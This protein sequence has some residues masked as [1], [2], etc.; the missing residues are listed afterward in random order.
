MFMRARAC[1][2][3]LYEVKMRFFMLDKITGWEVGVSAR[4]V[5]CVS[6]SED[7]FDDHFPGHPV[8]PGVLITEAMAQLG[9][10]LLEDTCLREYG[11]KIKAVLSI[12]DNMKFRSMAK[13]GDVLDIVCE[14]TGGDEFCGRVKV[15]ASAAERI[16]AQGT[17]VF[18]YL[19]EMDE[20]LE[21]KRAELLNFWKEGIEAKNERA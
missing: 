3:I 11:K 17:L 9:G 14:I 18:A 6:L 4:G 2:Y 19:D 13:P 15:K 21:K 1:H 10:L 20:E 16:V 8:M 5:K 7:F 12:V